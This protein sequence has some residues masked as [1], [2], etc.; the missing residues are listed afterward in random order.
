M[1]LISQNPIFTYVLGENQHKHGSPTLQRYCTEV[2]IKKKAGR[3]WNLEHRT[4]VLATDLFWGYFPYVQHLHFL[5]QE[6]GA[7]AA[8]SHHVLKSFSMQDTY[9]YCYFRGSYTA[10]EA[11]LVNFLFFHCDIASTDC[12]VLILIQP[13]F[14]SLEIFNARNFLLWSLLIFAFSLSNFQMSGPTFIIIALFWVEE[15]FKIIKSNY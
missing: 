12:N 2:K 5:M 1:Q 8:E 3:S 4:G 10:Q 7:E 9:R 13:F 15:T 6:Q 14:F 11:L